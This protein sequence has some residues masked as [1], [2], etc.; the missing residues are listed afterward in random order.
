MTFL[1]QKK[2]LIFLLLCTILFFQGILKLPVMDRDEARFATA[3]KTMIET[4]DFV[5]IKMLEESRYKKPIG[6]YWSQV[7]ANYIFGHEPYDKIW[8]YRLPSLFGI[9]VSFLLIYFYLFRIYNKDIA[10]ISIY[11]LICSILTISEMHQAKTD[12]LLFLTVNAANLLIF[13]LVRTNKAKNFLKIVFLD[14]FGIWG[15]N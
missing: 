13:E 12:G 15:S 9:L 4:K 8:V 7:L 6:I 5:D 1:K 3:T 2:I 10:F 14:Y 11:F